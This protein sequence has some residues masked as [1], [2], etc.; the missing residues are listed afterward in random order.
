MALVCRELDLDP[1]RYPPRSFSAQVSNLKNELVDE[2]TYAGTVERGH[3][4]RADA[5]RGVQ[6]VPA[7]AAAGQRDRLRRPDHDDG[8]HPAGLPGRRRAL[9]P[10]VPARPRRRV[11]GH[12]PRPVRP[13]PRAGRRLAVAG[14]GPRRATRERGDGADGAAVPPAELTVVGDADQSI[15]AFRGATIRNIL[16]FEDDYPNARTILLE[17]NY[18]STQTILTAAN[19]VIERNPDRKPKRL[20]TDAGAGAADHRLRRRQRARRGVVHRRGDRPAARTPARPGPATSPS[21]TGRTPSP[22]PW[23][24]C[25]SGSACRTRWSAA[26]GSTSAARSRTP[27]P[28]CAC[29]PTPTTP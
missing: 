6:R 3:P 7:A 17:Q 21:S 24:R 29:W 5:R 19:A 16:E 4:H 9:P 13:R 18:R 12:Q 10:P 27:W 25:S 11:P 8:Q 22:G 2:E 20:W 28:T 15:Y 26:P 1:K 23:R 14:H